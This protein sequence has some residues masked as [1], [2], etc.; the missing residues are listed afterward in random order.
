MMS[1]H[2]WHVER[3]PELPNSLGE[4][5]C[6]WCGLWC[7]AYVPTPRHGEHAGLTRQDRSNGPC[8]LAPTGKKKKEQA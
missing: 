2:C 5:R 7:R 4:R 1:K 8:D 6:C 3:N